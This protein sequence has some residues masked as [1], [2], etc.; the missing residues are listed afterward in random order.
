M[1]MQPVSNVQAARLEEKNFKK[2]MKAGAK[3][4]KDIASPAVPVKAVRKAD[5]SGWESV[6]DDLSWCSAEARY[7]DTSSLRRK[8]G[9]ICSV[10]S[11][12]KLHL[13]HLLVCSIVC[14]RHA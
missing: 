2:K 5:K 7:L 3:S 6:D 13:G 4:G 1:C 11:R 14:R 8:F 12:V 9:K 10:E